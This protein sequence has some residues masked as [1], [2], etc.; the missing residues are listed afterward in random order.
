MESSSQIYHA[1]II[2]ILPIVLSTL[3]YNISNV[4]D[5]GIFNAIL[6]GQGYTEEQYATIWGIYSGKFR[7]L[8]NVPCRWHPVWARRWYPA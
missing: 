5:Q 3:V 2:T 4:L 1:L 6:K 8:M 7:V